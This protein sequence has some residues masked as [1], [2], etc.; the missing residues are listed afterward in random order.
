MR[1]L[2]IT[3]CLFLL[4]L[5]AV[6]A[7]EK[8]SRNDLQQLSTTAKYEVQGADVVTEHAATPYQLSNPKG[9][10]IGTSFWPMQTNA[11]WHNRLIANANG[12]LSVVW[13][14]SGSDNASRG[15][16][17]NSY[18]NGAW[19]GTSSARIETT[20][21]GWGLIAPLGNGGEIVVSHNG[22]TGLLINKRA[23][24]G[25]GAWQQSVLLGPTITRPSTGTSSTALLWP[26]LATVGDTVHIFALTESDTGY[27]YNG[28]QTCL[29]YYRSTDNGVNWDISHQI[30]A[31]LDAAYIPDFSSDAYTLAAKP[32]CVALLYGEHFTDLFLLK[33]L[34]GGNT[35]TNTMVFDNPIPHTLDFNTDVFDTTFVPNKTYALAFDDN[36]NAH[37]AFGVIRVLRDNSNEPGYYS[38]Y[39]SYTTLVYWNE[40]MPAFANNKHALNPDTLA[41]A[42]PLFHMPE[43]TGNHVDSVYFFN[44]VGATMLNGKYN[45]FGHLLQPQ[46]YVEGN[47]VYLF[48]VSALP[49]PFR[50]VIS[51]AYWHGI[52][53]TKSTDGGATWSKTNVSWLSYDGELFQVNWEKFDAHIS[54]GLTQVEALENEEDGALLMYSENAFPSICLQN[55]IFHVVWFNDALSGVEEA[56]VANP[57]PFPCNSPYNLY[58]MSV[59]KDQIGT[60]RNTRDIPNN[61]WNNYGIQ[62][63]TLSASS[64]YP[65]PVSDKLNMVVASTKADKAMVTMTNMLGQT[66]YS[67]A[68]NLTAGANYIDIDVAGYNAG[69]Y[70]VN[71]KTATGVVAHKVVVK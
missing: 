41:E 25:Q 29:V 49:Y 56:T 13:P 53:A 4:G 35:W 30:V 59:P 68:E 38:Y 22:T 11:S 24:A 47:T 63:N 27:L 52:F 12:T 66:V 10:Y 32:G 1:K 51:T 26:V 64:I 15:T 6:Q 3:L 42:Y 40:T 43:L 34:D 55:D 33:S 44:A 54:A 57:N 45:S 50:D 37:I 21:A 48:Y 65:N 31:G 36:N 18:S 5:A 14:T 62:N 71:V 28:I 8:V 19:T 7:Q 16:G 69:I 17:Y 61:L 46:L 39:P 2:T 20:R 9:S 60:Y 23:E 70:I 58:Y 67:R